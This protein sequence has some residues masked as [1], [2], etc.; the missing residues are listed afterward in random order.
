MEGGGDK[1][2]LSKLLCLICIEG[3]RVL[4]GQMLDIGI[5]V[6]CKDSEAATVSVCPVYRYA[7]I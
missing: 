7:Y 4:A 6:D 1:G 2:R 3:N 5:A